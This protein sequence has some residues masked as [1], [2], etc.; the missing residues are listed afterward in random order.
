[1]RPQ[2]ILL[3]PQG[4]TT[5]LFRAHPL[6]TH[7]RTIFDSI[8]P[9]LQESVCY[10]PVL[11][12]KLNNPEFMPG[13]IK[14]KLINIYMFTKHLMLETRTVSSLSLMILHIEI[15]WAKNIKNGFW[16]VMEPHFLNCNM[17]KMKL[18][19]QRLNTILCTTLPSLYL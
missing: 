9:H 12:E 11:S 14:D 18:F 17:K 10:L 19:I 6:Q 16:S 4:S 3:Q 13:K 2:L 5:K 15:S 1:M 7:T 8:Q